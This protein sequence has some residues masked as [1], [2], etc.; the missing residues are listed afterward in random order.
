[1][2]IFSKSPPTP[3]EDQGQKA[4]QKRQSLL[5]DEEIE[6]TQRKLKALA[7]GKLGYKSLLGGV[8]GA[9]AGRTTQTGAKQLAPR[10]S[11]VSPRISGG[12][13]ARN[14]QSPGRGTGFVSGS[15]R[16]GRA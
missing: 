5:A 11:L 14:P 4:L 6:K 8:S 3:P 1:M 7:R 10:S 9:Q 16:T 15:A 13:G 2:G 12:G